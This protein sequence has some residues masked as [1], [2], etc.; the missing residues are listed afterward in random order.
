MLCLINNVILHIFNLLI[1]T[2]NFQVVFHVL[3]DA[4]NEINLLFCFKLD[5]TLNLS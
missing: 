4:I 2:A 1:E 3:I 5:P